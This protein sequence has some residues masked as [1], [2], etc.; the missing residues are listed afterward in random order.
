MRDGKKSVTYKRLDNNSMAECHIEWLTTMND[1]ESLRDKWLELEEIVNN[2]TVFAS[3]DYVIPWYRY[4][5]GNKHEQYGEPLLGV[6]WRGN[7]IIGIAPLICWNGT[8]GKIPVRRIDFIG[9]MSYS[10]EFL[11]PDENPEIV[12]MFTGSLIDRGGF[13]VIGLHGWDMGSEKFRIFNRSVAEHDM[14]LE[15]SGY[16]YAMID[17]SNGYKKY[18]ESMSRN[19]R[20]NKKRHLEKI[21]GM[22][23]WGIDLIKGSGSPEE[24]S[25]TIERMV[26]IYNCSWK[27]RHGGEIGDHHRRFYE[28]IVN[29][30]SSRKMLYFCV[31]S[32]NR[33][34]AAFFLAAVERGVL[35]D[36]FLSYNDR[37]KDLRPGEFL[38][39]QITERLP[40]MGVKTFI[41]HGDH[42]YKRRWAT[43]FIPQYQTYIFSHGIRSRM[44]RIM[45]F[46]IQ[47]FIEKAKK[48]FRLPALARVNK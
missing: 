6:A 3:C 15:I 39:N 31:L 42:E 37:F 10:G 16:R 7:Q 12:G 13:D 11:V 26:S 23:E 4:Y 20:R 17:L 27:V 46:R 28:E 38:I 30:L 34:D 45:K 41:S 22:G 48:D 43:H 24:I 21:S 32:I 8:L 9:F 5:R 44:S 2:R 36:I 29:R 33:E 35:Y 14:R 47:P 19:F 18:C 40:E 25:R 1:I